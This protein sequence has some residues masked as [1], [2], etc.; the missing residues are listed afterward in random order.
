MIGDRKPPRGRGRRPLCNRELRNSTRE[1][2]RDI[3]TKLSGFPF[4][5]AAMACLCLAGGAAIT[6]LNYLAS[7]AA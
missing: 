2:K 3:M 4:A 1:P 5:Y 6:G 7:L